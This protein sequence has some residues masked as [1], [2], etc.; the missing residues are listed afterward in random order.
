MISIKLS[1]KITLLYGRVP[2]VF[3]YLQNI[4]FEEHIREVASIRGIAFKEHS[5]G[6]TTINWETKKHAVDFSHQQKTPKILPSS[7]TAYE[8]FVKHLI[9]INVARMPYSCRKTLQGCHIVV[10]MP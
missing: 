5:P 2:A 1:I 10:K 3:V 9:I 4:F 7:L 6:S 8:T